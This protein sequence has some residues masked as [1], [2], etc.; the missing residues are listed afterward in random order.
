LV[1]FHMFVLEKSTPGSNAG[2][3][4]CQNREASLPRS[5]MTSVMMPFN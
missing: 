5:Y 1:P 4:S 3:I 2:A